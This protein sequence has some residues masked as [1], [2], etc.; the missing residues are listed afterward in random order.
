PGI[1]DI[2]IDAIYKGTLYATGSVS[3]YEIIAGQVNTVTTTMEQTLWAVLTFENITIN[4]AAVGYSGTPPANVVIA[5]NGTAPATISSIT[6]NRPD[7]FTMPPPPAGITAG[8]NSSLLVT[9]AASLP[10]GT[11]SA[12][13]TVTYSG[14]N[15]SVVSVTRNISFT[16]TPIAALPG[17]VTITPAT[18]NVGGT[19]TAEYSG[20]ETVT[21]QWN[22]DGNPITSATGTTHTPASPGSYTVTASAAG[23]SPKTSAAVTVTLPTLSGNVTITGDQWV[24]A[25]L[26]ANT[27]GITNTSGTPTY[28]W[29]RGTTNIGSNSASYQITAQDL[30]QTISVT[31]TYSGNAGSLTSTPTAT[32]NRTGIYSGEDFNAIVATR[33][34]ILAIDS[35]TFST[36]LEINFTGT[37]DGNGKTIALNITTAITTTNGYAGLFTQIGGG[38][39]VKNLKLTGSIDITD[40]ANLYVGAVAGSNAGNIFNVSSSVNVNVTSSN[41]ATNCGGI[42]GNNTGTIRNCYSTGDISGIASTSSRVGGIAGIADGNTSFSWASGN[43]NGSHDNPGSRADIGGICGTASL[44]AS[45]VSNC[46]ALNNSVNST[47]YLYRVKGGTNGTH[48]N[49]HAISTMTTTSPSWSSN[50]NTG[51]HG[52]DFTTPDWDAAW[53]GS[54]DNP[55]WSTVWVDGSE[56]FDNKPW[57]WG[58]TRPILWFETTVNQ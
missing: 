34:Y 58:V 16:V 29:R 55:N 27:T 2:D 13:I 3:D 43:I 24:N 10:I 46:V 30:N 6:T 47:L 37:F 44:A 28:Q 5:N 8:G 40:T 12:Q 50:G 49:N 7:L 18:A 54:G 25:T 4:N 42:A 41:G 11:H 39:V 9:A 38:G 21:F 15:T 20:T 52:T 33:N 31:V 14:G 56:D 17:N 32:I 51:M 1:W 19:L 22:F 36:P 57:K 35:L 53:F 26:T 48:D 23:F 45:V